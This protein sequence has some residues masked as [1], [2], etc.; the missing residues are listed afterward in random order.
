MKRV[1]SWSGFALFGCHCVFYLR[2]RG[3]ERERE[4]ERESITHHKLEKER[5]DITY[6]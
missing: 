3:R 4:R 5:K 1:P 6:A 2:E